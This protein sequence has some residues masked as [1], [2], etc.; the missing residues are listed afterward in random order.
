MNNQST[1][2]AEFALK[3]YSVES[4]PAQFEVTQNA[5]RQIAESV[6]LTE[7]PEDAVCSLI[8]DLMHYCEKKE[9]DWETDVI[10]RAHIRFAMERRESEKQ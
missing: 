3:A 1:A 10:S 7:A 6:D 5:R 4:D 9:I 2:A 8:L